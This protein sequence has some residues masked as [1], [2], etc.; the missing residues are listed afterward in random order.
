[1]SLINELKRR[2]VIRIGAGYVVT[3]WLIIQV[4]ET[5][6]PIYGLSDRAIRFVISGLAV[7]LLPALILAWAF[8]W[9]PE[10]IRKDTGGERPDATPSASAKRL[11]RAIM[12]VLAIAVA[13]FAADKFVFS[14]SR[15]AAIAEAARKAGRSEAIVEAYGERSIAVLAFEDMSPDK[16]QAYMSDGI[17]EEILNLLARVP[18]L[19]VISRS[20]A[21][22][23]KGK[24]LPIPEIAQQLNAAYIL[25][26]S[27][28][29][30]GDQLR[31]TAQ[32]IDAGSDTHRWSRTYDRR[33]ENVFD[34]QDDIAAHVVEELKSTLLGDA[35]KSQRLDEEAYTLVLQARYLWYR[36]AEGDEEEALDLYRRA[37]EMDPGYGPA[38][39]GL[40][41]AYAVA[42]LKDRID[43]QE[44]L[45]LSR[46]AVE[47]ALELDPGDAEA[48]VRLGQA[49]GRAGDFRGM[50]A[51]FRKALEFA[52]NNPLTLGAAAQQAGRHG[53]LDRVVELYDAAAAVDPLGAIWPGN[54]ATWLIRFR[55]AEEAQQALDRSFEL[56]GNRSSYQNGMVEVLIL[57]GEFAAALEILEDLPPD[58]P[59]LTRRAIALDGVGR[60][61]ESEAL[62]AEIKADEHPFAPMG[63]AQVYAVR[64]ENDLA[65]EWLEKAAPHVE[66]WNLVYDQYT[67]YLVE[68]PRW[69]GF[70]DSL[71]WPWEYQY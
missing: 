27:V 14:E 42:A 20:S 40:S 47:K 36:R 21:F 9:T 67:R 65:F 5:I 37:V 53:R 48:H 33:L 4:V 69:K 1:M 61:E 71:D 46:E 6:F 56:N 15:E 41:V 68:D 30:A 45:K 3:S 31:I 34:I 44:G 63:V 18:D 70:V 29:K 25:E 62:L 66:P 52:P 58:G 19:R 49:Y 64:G 7:G 16:D 59:N 8:E 32:L 38:W 55:R 51:Q 43:R 23:F 22:A 39:T 13:Y 24:D 60:H 50:M 28:R 17:S 11:D 26:G 2:N 10:G 12:V 57:R 35:P 54:K